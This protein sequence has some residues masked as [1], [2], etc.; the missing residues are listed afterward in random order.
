MPTYPYP[1][2]WEYASPRQ[3]RRAT[4]SFDVLQTRA[5]PVY[6]GPLMVADDHE[7]TVQSPQAV[8][9]RLLVLWAVE[10]RAEGVSQAETLGLIEQQNLWAAVSPVEKVFLQN[11]TPPPDECLQLTWRL[12]SIWALLWAMRY[13]EELGWPSEQC[14]VPALAEMVSDLEDDLEFI[15]AAT[16]RPI[17]EILDAQDLT[18]RIHWAIRDA[19]LHQGGMIPEDLDWS[20]RSDY[21]PV[22]LSGAVGVVEERHGALK[23]LANDTNS[24]DWD[25]PDTST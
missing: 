18:M 1:E 20:G 12:E 3:A 11:E 8:A 4:R 15:L 5:V 21:V 23:W 2:T 22:S 16:L 9:R 6:G 10:L 17:A 25:D 24:H 14:D 19:Y 13:V 7:V